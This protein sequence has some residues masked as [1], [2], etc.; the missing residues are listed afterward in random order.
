LNRTTP[1]ALI[2]CVLGFG[3]AANVCAAP[4][5]GRYTGRYQCQVW[6]DMQVEIRDEGGGNLS[7]TFSAEFQAPGVKGTASYTLVGTYDAASGRVQLAPNKWIRRPS[8]PVTMTGFDGM[9]DSATGR[10]KGKVTDFNCTQF[11][12]VPPGVEIGALPG[13]PP[14]PLPP[15]R[16]KAVT[17]VTDLR[18]PYEYIDAAMSDPPGTVRESEP[19]DDVIDWLRK[20][21]FSCVDTAH[22][23]WDATGTKG[24][25]RD[26]VRTRERYVLECD[27]D[28]RGVRYLPYVGAGVLH[29]G[30]LEPVPVLEIKNVWLGDT[31][32]QWNV[33]RDRAT[34]PPPDIYIHRW[35]SSGF[36]AKGACKAPKSDNK[37]GAS[38]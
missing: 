31:A 13:P 30:I 23:S 35:T 28:C 9:R 17:V 38:R 3:F 16:Q 12:I 1:V 15:E 24:V 14:P 36:N 8:M 19:I 25:A 21:G 22:V 6:R 7:G 5:G 37:S 2:L 29:F 20:D 18:T 33:T 11:E 32:F 26:V 34:Q 27:G 10:I 4:L